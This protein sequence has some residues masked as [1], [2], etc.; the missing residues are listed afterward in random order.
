MA[1][2][3]TPKPDSNFYILDKRISEDKSLGWAARGLLVFILGKPDHWSL[4]VQNLINETKDA[5][6]KSARDRVY[7]ILN[8]LIAAGYIKRDG[9]SV[10]AGGKFSSYNYMV[11][12]SPH[13]G[14]PHTGKPRTGKPHTDKPYT[15]KPYTDKPN[16]V[17]TDV[18][19]GLNLVNG[20]L[21]ATEDKPV[22]F[23]P[24]AIKPSNVTDEQWSEWIRY[25]RERKISCTP[26]TIR[27]Q[28]K[29]LEGEGNPAAVIAASITNGW[30]GLFPGKGGS[31][32]APDID[33]E[34]RGWMS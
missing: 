14:K 18:K 4:S 10:K 3:R 32:G 31:A 7:S 33:F 17:S 27:K 23:N 34:S 30:A 6:D 20:S 13:T 2:I 15:D 29:M 19:Q 12:D 16:L 21:P 5:K 9:Q 1:I 8:E 22:K 11:F 25:R 24:L 28:I 26:M